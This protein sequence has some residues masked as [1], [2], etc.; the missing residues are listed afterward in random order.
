MDISGDG[1]STPL[2]VKIK[3]GFKPILKLAIEW[4]QVADGNWYAQD[5]G[6]SADI[7]ASEFEVYRWESNI[8]DLIDAIEINR[9]N[10]SNVLTL[11][12]FSETEK[13]FGAD[14]DHTSLTATITEYGERK[15]RSWKGWSLSLKA[16]VMSPTFTGSS[17]LPV[18]RNI[19]VGYKGDT[20]TTILKYDSY[21]GSFSYIDYNYDSGIFEC[22]LVLKTVDM[23]S[24]RRFLA[25]NRATSF[26]LSSLYGVD[27]PFG[28]RRSNTYPINVKIVDFQDQGMI[29]VQRWK[30]KL[31]LA[32]TI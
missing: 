13:I 31:K 4:E 11:S 3:P 5:R 25:T 6:A 7:Y 24:M 22:N 32:E 17:S 12:N 28:P 26:S 2:T 8:N 20:D 10:F 21:T 15:Q 9:H 14:V 23:V 18:F 19:E 16:Q 27:Y 1:I 29:D 30:I